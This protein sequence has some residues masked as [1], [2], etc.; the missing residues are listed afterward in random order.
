MIILSNLVKIIIFFCPIAFIISPSVVNIFVSVLAIFS[1]I[2]IFVEKKYFLFKKK[3]SFF[4]I[5]FCFSGFVFHF[6]YNFESAIKSLLYLRFFLLYLLIVYILKIEN[7]EIKFFLNFITCIVLIISFDLLYQYSFS[8]NII[9]LISQK[10]NRMSSFFGKELIAGSYI[11]IFSLFVFYN[12]IKLNNKFTFI[13]FNFLSLLL[14]TAIFVTFE[15]MAIIKFI[16]IVTY[17][18]IFFNLIKLQSF[19]KIKILINIIFIIIAILFIMIN[20]MN[21]P[22]YIERLNNSISNP[23]KHDNIYFNLLIAGVDIFLS[24]PYIG[25]GKKNYYNYCLN[26]SDYNLDILTKTVE[27]KQK[28][29]AKQKGIDFTNNHLLTVSS[30]NTL[31]D[32]TQIDGLYVLTSLLSK[33]VCSTHPHNVIISLLVETGIIG[34]ILFLGFLFFECKK[35]IFKK[36]NFIEFNFLTLYL[37]IMLFPAQISGNILQSFYGSIFWFCLSLMIF[38]NKKNIN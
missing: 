19:K 21:R 37:L 7:K 3:S 12:L 20:L 2:F 18:F 38:I 35:I 4:I 25:V 5:L 34:F 17:L 33:H 30:T 8:E 10:E 13:F 23:I 27:R 11:V 6:H 36:D 24:K 9:G 29:T 32:F 22:A 31:D 15:R 14:I 26:H 1:A 28:E 16:F